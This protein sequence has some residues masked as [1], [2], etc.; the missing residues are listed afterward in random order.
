MT[1]GLKLASLALALDSLYEAAT[2]STGGIIHGKTTLAISCYP[3]ISCFLLLYDP[4]NQLSVRA[5]LGTHSILN[6]GSELRWQTYRCGVAVR[7]CL[8]RWPITLSY[9]A[10]TVFSIVLCI[11]LLAG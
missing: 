3:D 7:F 9:S 2:K 4:A 1:V 11:S 6:A 5:G 10:N 8:A